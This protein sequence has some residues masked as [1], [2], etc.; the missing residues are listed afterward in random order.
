M[1]RGFEPPTESEYNNRGCSS[2]AN[3]WPA[4]F[5]AKKNPHQRIRYSECAS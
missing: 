2:V 3:D 1:G 5:F 4:N